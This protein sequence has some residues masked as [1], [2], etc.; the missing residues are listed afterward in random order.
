ML[1]K[2]TFINEESQNPIMKALTAM[3]TGSTREAEPASIDG[4]VLMAHWNP[5]FVIK[6]IADVRGR[7][8]DD[9]DFAYPELTTADGDYIPNY[10]VCDSLEQFDALYGDTLRAHAHS[11]I[12]TFVEIRRDEQPADGG[13]RYHKWGEYV[14]TQEPMHEYLHDD[15]HIERVFTF[16]LHRVA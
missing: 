14:G 5:E 11:F 15:T 12:V 1:I 4:Y 7:C 16:A 9:F 3:T 13:W 8:R 2:P 10:G 6:E